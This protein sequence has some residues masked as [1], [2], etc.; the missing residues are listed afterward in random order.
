V[1][2]RAVVS[3]NVSERGVLCPRSL[4]LIRYRFHAFRVNL[5]S[6]SLIEFSTSFPGGGRMSFTSIEINQLCGRFCAFFQ[7]VYSIL[8]DN[9]PGIIAAIELVPAIELR[10]LINGVLIGGRARADKP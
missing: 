2:N 3:L 6:F 1:S 5:R 9:R 7:R 4:F 8:V 10:I